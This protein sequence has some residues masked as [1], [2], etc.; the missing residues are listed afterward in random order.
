MMADIE[1]D[2]KSLN[3]PRLVGTNLALVTWL[4]EHPA[5]SWIVAGSLFENGGINKMRRLEIN[6]PPT[7]EPHPPKD[8]RFAASSPADPGEVLA[9]V[10]FASDQHGFAYPTVHDYA[11]A[12]REGS[13]TPEMVAE[14][15]LV[16]IEASNSSQQPLRAIIDCQH[17]DVLAQACAATQRIQSGRAL[18]L[19]D[20]VP[21]A[22]KDEFD[23]ISYRTC[24]GTS[25]LGEKPATEDAF[26]VGRLRAAGALLIGKANMHEIGIGVTGFNEHHGTARNPYN[27][28]HHT[29]GSSSGPAASV[30]AS[31]SPLAL[32]ADGGGSIR[33]PSALCGVVGLK[34][35]FG[36]VSEIGAAPTNWTVAH[37]GPIGA[38]AQD[39]AIGYLTIA[40]PDPHDPHTLHQPAPSLAGFENQ[41]L[42]D[43]TLGVY[44]PWFQHASTDI[45]QAC[46]RALQ[47]F[48]NLGAKVREVCIPELDPVRVAHMVTITSE[49]AEGLEEAYANHRKEFSLEVRYDLALARMFTA[50]DYL[51][52]QRVRTRHIA[53][54]EQTFQEVNLIVT[55]STAITAPPIRPD[56]LTRGESDINVLTELMRYVLSA[57]FTGHPAISFPVGYDTQGLPIGMQAIGHYWEEHVLL[58]LAH[59]H[60]AFYE[61]RKPQMY[62]SLIST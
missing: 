43:L 58:R 11:R 3:L 48:Q 4:V 51:Q 14:R 29:G 57:N 2:L 25:F 26:S 39:A 22:V 54:L 35:T 55:P 52:A 36:R 42:S 28:E 33:L 59:A 5:T 38:T 6:E 1:Y 16:A 32:G 45:V 18:S 56:A 50:R 23:M 21:V 9:E 8:S 19:L 61:R 17:E 60:E 30:A 40:G 7:F 20:G 24:D 34:P 49:M 62:F 44:T 31:L 15:V 10:N 37:I 47:H 12:Y 13:L 53:S 41:D 46:E 27:L